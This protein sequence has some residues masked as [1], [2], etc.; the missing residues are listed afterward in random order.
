MTQ[1]GQKAE[2]D[3]LLQG[4]AEQA[5]Q[6]AARIKQEA[7]TQAREI[8]ENAKRKAE[9]LRQEARAKSEQQAESIRLKNEQNI[10]AEQRK[11]QLKAQEELFSLALSKVRETLRK[12]MDLSDYK[13]IL[14]AWIVE[15]AIGLGRDELTANASAEERKLLTGT[16]LAQAEKE[17]EK[18]TGLRVKI[19]LSEDAPLQKQGVSLTSK[20]GRL[21]F[22]NTVEARMQRYATAV[23]RM[24]YRQ[25]QA[26]EKEK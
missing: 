3:Q 9:T 26:D 6:E 5:E 13:E 19:T 23:R 14:R 16:M 15:A 8:V 18:Q 10:E 25:I 11:R 4:I 22:N 21:A 2:G 20:N 24:I 17:V 1:S 7:E 12:R